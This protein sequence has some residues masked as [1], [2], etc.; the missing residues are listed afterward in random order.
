MSLVLGYVSLNI[1]GIDAIHSSLNDQI[2]MYPSFRYNRL[3]QVINYLDI[4]DFGILNNEAVRPNV[5]PYRSLDKNMNNWSNAFIF[6]LGPGF[7]TALNNDGE[8]KG[9]AGNFSSVF[10]KFLS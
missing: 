9:L 2:G 6:D 5:K 10:V 7:D 1:C 8:L 3:D 4:V